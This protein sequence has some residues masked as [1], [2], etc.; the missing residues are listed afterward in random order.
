MRSTRNTLGRHEEDENQRLAKEIW[1]SWD[2]R[3]RLDE[4]SKVRP[5]DDFHAS[6]KITE[7][8]FTYANQ[9]VEEHKAKSRTHKSISIL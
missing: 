5:G 1:Y 6:R 4:A 8:D 2:C 9:L 3:Y 7:H